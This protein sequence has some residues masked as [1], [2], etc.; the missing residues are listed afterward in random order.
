MNFSE[1]MQEVFTI[2]NRPDL[3]TD[4]ASAIQKAT[5]KFHLAETFDKDLDTAI[6]TLPVQNSPQYSI[7]IPTTSQLIRPRKLF[8]VREYKSATMDGTE[9]VFTRVPADRLLDR[10]HMQKQNIFYE[11]GRNLNLVAQSVISAILITYYKFPDTSAATYDSW[12]GDLYGRFVAE[13]A[14]ARV[15][16]SIGKDE[17]A[18]RFNK[19]FMENFHMIQAQE[20]SP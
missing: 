1:L 3:L 16:K 14:A 15:F 2:T 19:L 10:F 12:I 13:E 11:V 6:V 8:A 5:L 4:T 17:E 7:N 18:E 20:I 9:L